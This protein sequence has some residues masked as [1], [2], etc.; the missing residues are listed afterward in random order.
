MREMRGENKIGYCILFDEIEYYTSS[1]Y[2]FDKVC[3]GRGKRR[4]KGRGRGKDI[5]KS[6]KRKK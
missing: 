1:V 4:E 3:I 6:R 2:I 5:I